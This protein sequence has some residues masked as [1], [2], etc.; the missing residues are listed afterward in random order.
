MTSRCLLLPGLSRVGNRTFRSLS[1]SFSG[2]MGPKSFIMNKRGFKYNSSERRTPNILGTLK[3]RTIM[4]G[5]FT[6]VFCEGSVGVNLPMVIYGSL[7][8]RMGA[9]SGVILRVSRKAI[10]T[11]KGACSYAG[12]PRCVRGV[13]GRNNLVTSL[14]GRRG[15]GKGSGYEGSCYY[16][17]EY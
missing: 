4:T 14:G 15:W 1:P 12:L 2:G 9:K 6:Q 11:G 10:R 3:M 5:S 13:L 8:S 17:D 7:P 16:N